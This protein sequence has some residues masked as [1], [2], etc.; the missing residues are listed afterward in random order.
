MRR[1]SRQA[2]RNQSKTVT[3]NEQQRP[4]LL[5]SKPATP[6]TSTTGIDER[7]PSRDGGSSLVGDVFAAPSAIPANALD[8]LI[9]AQLGGAD[10]IAQSSHAQHAAAVGDDAIAV[11]RGAGM[12]NFDVS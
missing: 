9:S 12:K 10:V 4:L 6:A 7:L 8:S 2:S 3:P 11:T 1:R 5:F